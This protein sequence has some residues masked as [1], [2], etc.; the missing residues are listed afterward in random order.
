MPWATLCLL[1]VEARCPQQ[2]PAS[3]I[4]LHF[5]ATGLCVGTG[6]S[7]WNTGRLRAD[8]AEIGMGLT[9]IL[10]PQLPEC[11]DDRMQPHTI[12]ASG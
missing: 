7:Q 2:A 8:V 3:P 4:F 12:A 1:Q 6:G 9:A 10:L 11:P 5:P